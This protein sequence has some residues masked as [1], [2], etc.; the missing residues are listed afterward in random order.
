MSV[1]DRNRVLENDG[2]KRWEAEA[3]RDRSRRSA[4]GQPTLLEVGHPIVSRDQGPMAPG[5]T[6]QSPPSPTWKR[7]TKGVGQRPQQ[8]I[9]PYVPEN[10]KYL[11]PEWGSSYVIPTFYST[12]LM[13]HNKSII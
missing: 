9:Q 10:N 4:D 11:H 2:G 7:P 5:T 1:R 8:N 12:A 3:D 13:L 6:Q